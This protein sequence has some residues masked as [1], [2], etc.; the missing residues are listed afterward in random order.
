MDHNYFPYDMNH[1]VK[2]SK[3]NSLNFQAVIIVEL[4]HQTDRKHFTTFYFPLHLYLQ[5][6]QLQLNAF[7]FPSYNVIVVISL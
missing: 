3:A 1:T 2:D 7:I 6:L 5:C 4:V